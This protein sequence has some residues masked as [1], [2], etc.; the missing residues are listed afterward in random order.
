[1]VEEAAAEVVV[2]VIAEVVA[3]EEVEATLEAEVILEGEVD[4]VAE[5]R[6]QVPVTYLA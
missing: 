5:V 4:Q 1:M 6:R 2:G 3:T